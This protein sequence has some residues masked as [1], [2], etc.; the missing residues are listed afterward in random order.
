MNHRDIKT[1]LWNSGRVV[2]EDECGVQ[3]AGNATRDTCA[4]A[5]VVED[6]E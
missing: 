3:G 5:L 4:H 1:R 2:Y 6:V